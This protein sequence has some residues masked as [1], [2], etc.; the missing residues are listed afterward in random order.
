MARRR[1]A[2]LLTAQPNEATS[3]TDC[4]LSGRLLRGVTPRLAAGLLARN[5]EHLPSLR[6]ALQRVA[7]QADEAISNI[8]REQ[9]GRLLRG[10]TPRL[11]AGLLAR[12]DGVGAISTRNFRIFILISLALAA[13]AAPVEAPNVLG[14]ETEEAAE[15]TPG[16]E[17]A[18]PVRTE[19]VATIS[20]EQAQELSD[21]G[22]IAFTASEG[23]R[24]DVF[25]IRPDGTGEYNLTGGLANTFAEAPVWSWDGKLI[26]F[27]GIPNSDV[28]RDV[29]LVTVD[30]NPEQWQFTTQPGFDCYP[31]FSPDGEHIVYMKEHDKNRD[32]FI[33]DMEGNDILQLTDVEAHD[34][35]PNWS[36]DGEHI[37]F[38]TRR[39]GNSEIYVMDADG[40]N[41]TR[42]TDDPGLDWRPVFSP[43]GEW[44]VFESWRSGKGDIY[45]MRAD[46]SGLRQLTDSPSEDGNP[47]WS[48]DGRYIVFHSQRTG[49]YQLFILEVAHPENQWHLETSSVR[50]LL[51]VWSPITDIPGAG[52]LVQ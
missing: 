38:T 44:I 50:S 11:S 45:L 37:A 47:T 29:Y 26:A 6:G 30:P 16:A 52:Q 19:A 32:L 43:D 14:D 39:D 41:L 24:R 22:W 34:Y 48:P 15:S 31:S 13:C 8:V 46:G 4:R 28:L 12:N 27:D 49:N 25:L 51:P 10:V 35:E 36:P 2:P 3:N 17:T 1:F 18:T 9:C 5:D 7:M 21:L 40:S 20:A 23:G 42:L 33:A